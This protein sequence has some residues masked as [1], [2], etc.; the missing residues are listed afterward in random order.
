MQKSSKI[1]ITGHRGLVGSAITRKLQAEGYSNILTISSKELDLTRQKDVEDFFAAHKPEYVFHCAAR[2]GGIKANMSYPAEFMYENLAINTNVI[3]SAYKNNAKK[4]LFMG[5]SCVYPRLSQQ[6]MKEEYLLTGLVEPTNEYYALAKIAGIKMCESY[7][8]Q[9]NTN[10]ISVMPSNI[11]GR[12]D[13]CDLEHSHVMSALIIKMHTAKINNAPQVEVWGTGAARREFLN[14]E[15]LADASLFLML[16]YNENEIINIGCSY[17]IS[18]KELAELIKQIV[19]YAGE[20]FFDTTK[21]DGMPRKLVDSTKINNLG[22][23]S[24]ISLQEGIKDFYEYY[25]SQTK[26]N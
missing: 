15:D 25:L 16:N 3:N 21:P 2:V 23:K 12:G 7:N 20:L 11:Y 14:V 10:Y 6:P 4:L 24:K 26:G 17:D 8:K 13:S 18:I 9:Y 1:Y 22:W 19:G 5:S